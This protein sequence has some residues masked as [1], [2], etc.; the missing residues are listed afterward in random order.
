[1]GHTYSYINKKTLNF[2]K[3]Y[4]LTLFVD[5]GDSLEV[6]ISV[7][8][9]LRQ[10]LVDNFTSAASSGCETGIESVRFSGQLLEC[11]TAFFIGTDWV[12]DT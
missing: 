2:N 1:L 9:A 11:S 3:K 10:F 12:W 8:A 6:K 4:T 7:C 5:I